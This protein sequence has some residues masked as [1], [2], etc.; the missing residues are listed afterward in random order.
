MPLPVVLHREIGITSSK[1]LIHTLINQYT[2]QYISDKIL[3]FCGRLLGL[4][5]LKFSNYKGTTY[6]EIDVV[7]PVRV[8]S[9]ISRFSGV[10]GGTCMG[11][12]K[13]GRVFSWSLMK[14][15]LTSTI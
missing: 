14:L 3:D 2:W 9:H 11:I 12:K 4:T 7:E 10:W 6:R 8:M 15:T 5:H 13:A 1:A